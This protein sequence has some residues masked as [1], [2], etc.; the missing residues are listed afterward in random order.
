MPPPVLDSAG[1]SLGDDWMGSLALLAAVEE[2]G[3]Q[4]SAAEENNV[5]HEVVGFFLL[6]KEDGAQ[7]LRSQQI[8]RWCFAAALSMLTRLADDLRCPPDLHEGFWDAH[9]TPSPGNFAV[10]L[11]RVATLC[12]CR[13][14][15]PRC[16]SVCLSV[17]ISLFLLSTR[18][19]PDASS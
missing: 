14:V 13:M 2:S 16:I 11:S 19:S 10:I 8:F 7:L 3:V 6:L 17:F 4:G 1:Q 15:G 9:R 5:G 12:T 18:F